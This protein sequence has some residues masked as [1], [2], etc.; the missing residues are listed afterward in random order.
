MTSP[1]DLTRRKFAVNALSSLLLS[2][3]I[4]IPSL[5]QEP[6]PKL[7]QYLNELTRQQRF[8]GAAL[9]ARD[10]KILLSRG[11]AM[12]NRELEVP[13]TPQTRFRLGSIT[14]QFTGVAMMIL[15][16]QGK[17]NVQDPVC[18]YV[19]NCPPVWDEA[20]ITIHHLLTHTSG[21]PSFTGFP[22]YR[23]T[24]MIPATIEALLG[25]FRDRPL[26]FRPEEK[27]NYSNSG[28]VLLGHI[29]EKVSG[30]SYEAFLQEQILQPLKLT[31]TGYDTFGRIIPR[32]ASGYTRGADG[33]VNA[34]FLDMSIPHA[35]GA[36]YSTVED[37]YQWDQALNRSALLSPKS[38]EAIYTPV[39]NNYGYGWAIEQQF[40]RRRISHGGGINGFSSYIAR[41]PN[42]RVT[43]IV[44]SNFDFANAGRIARDLGAIVFGEKYEMPVE[45]TAVKV[46][47]KIFDSYVGRYEL[48]PDFIFTI[49]RDGDRL[50]LEATGQPQAELF[51]ESATKFFLKVVDAQVTFVKNEAGE[52]T[53]LI[54]HQGGDRQAKKIK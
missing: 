30:K 9:I 3:L 53:H 40:N 15:Q 25:R 41:Y 38:F 35:A 46:D 16:E 23:Q 4:V 54:L 19:A 34:P 1:R 26:E 42:D 13:N 5:A 48:R 47:P 6:G 50:L 45:R 28:Y 36:L 18:K 8:S 49:T 43:I 20:K 44:L 37:L 32:R 11:Y 39:K 31:S 12:A 29:I 22:D 27:W 52:V 33:I 24:M 51:P 17:L 10:G 14:K 7:D 2:L 21:I